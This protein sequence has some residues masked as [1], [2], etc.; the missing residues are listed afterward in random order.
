MYKRQV[1]RSGSNDWHGSAYFFY[2]DHNMAAYPNLDRFPGDLNPFFVRRNPGASLGG[3]LIKDK[4]F[5]FF[6]YEFL[7]QVQA[8]SVTTTDP[9]FKGIQG[10]YPSPYEAKKITLR[11]DYHLNSKNNLFA[12]YSHDGND[13]FGPAL[14]FGDPSNWPH[15]VN[16]SDQSILGV[17]SILTPTLVND[18]RFEYN[19]WNCLLYTSVLVW[20]RPNG[21]L[22]PDQIGV[23][24]ATIYLTG[25][26]SPKAAP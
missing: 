16:W 1:T 22:S 24:F 21:P 14:T 20:F 19:Y 12:R 2:R 26:A 13:G 5:F 3:P 18:L 9:A 6:N 7:N 23:L 10:T 25:A 4:L 15:N 8:Q 11:L 17:T